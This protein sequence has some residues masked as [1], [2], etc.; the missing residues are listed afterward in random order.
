MPELVHVEFSYDWANEFGFCDDCGDL[1]ACYRAPELT[2]TLHL[3]NGNTEVHKGQNLC[4]ICAALWASY[5]EALER[6]WKGDDEEPEPEKPKIRVYKRDPKAPNP[7]GWSPDRLWMVG[8]T[9]EDS[10]ET[11]YATWE[12]AMRWATMPSERRAEIIEIENL[13]DGGW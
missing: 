8:P 9:P 12:Q 13:L 3:A 1:P 11:C 7:M 2:F 10:R 6:L 5:G 4:P